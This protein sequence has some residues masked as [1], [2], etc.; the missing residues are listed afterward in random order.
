MKERIV[1]TDVPEQRPPRHNLR[2]EISPRDYHYLLP[3]A[4]RQGWTLK[5]AVRRIINCYVSAAIEGGN[6][7]GVI[8]EPPAPRRRRKEAEA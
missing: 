2:V 3:L 5:Y 7:L 1:L 8:P 4:A 6:P